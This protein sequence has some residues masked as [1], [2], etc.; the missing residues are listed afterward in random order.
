MYGGLYDIAMYE[1]QYDTAMYGGQYDIRRKQK[2][3]RQGY[4]N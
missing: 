3:R 1:G 4:E 2:A